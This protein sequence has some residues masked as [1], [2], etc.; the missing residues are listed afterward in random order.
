LGLG[1]QQVSVAR[2]QRAMIERGLPGRE[3]RGTAAGMGRKAE[4]EWA[5]GF[6]PFSFYY[7]FLFHFLF[8]FS[9]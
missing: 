5:A 2:G 8:V 9:F 7:E 3:R 4:G 1:C 6:I